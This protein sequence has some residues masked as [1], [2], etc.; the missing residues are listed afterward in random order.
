MFGMFLV[1]S[2]P[3]YSESVGEGPVLVIFECWS[4]RCFFLLL[5]PVFHICML[6]IYYFHNGGLLIYTLVL[7]NKQKLNTKETCKKST[8]TKKLKEKKFKRQ[9]GAKKCTYNLK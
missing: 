8:V 6:S 5:V 9:I 1:F 3:S 4:G 2:W 7:L